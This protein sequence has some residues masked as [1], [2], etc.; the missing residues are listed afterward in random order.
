MTSICRAND[1]GYVATVQ[2]GTPPQN[3]N[4]LMDSGSADLWVGA[5]GCQSQQGGDCGNHQF[6]GPQSSSTFV[7]SN[8]QFEVQYG[9]GA[10]AG[11]LVTDNVNIAGLQLNTHTF[12]VALLESVQF[13]SD[14][15][16]FDGLM[17]LAQSVITVF[18]AKIYTSL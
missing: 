5:E 1:V 13:S 18:F 3:F 12:G 14:S 7:A 2:M 17:G 8:D 9:S 4:I 15:V 16:A 10:V 6:L 11:T